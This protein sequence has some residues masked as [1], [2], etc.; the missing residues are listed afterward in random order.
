MRH[1][2]WHRGTELHER[3]CECGLCNSNG[4]THS[5]AVIAIPEEVKTEK[6]LYNVIDDLDPVEVF[7][8]P[9]ESAAEDLAEAY[10]EEHQLIYFEYE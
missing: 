5:Y 4:K 3:D 6:D 7:H 2:I 9:S 8:A 10:F 1:V